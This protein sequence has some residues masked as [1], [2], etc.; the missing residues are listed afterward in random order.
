M[1]SRGSLV[2]TGTATSP[3]RMMPKYAARYSAR[4][5]DRMPMRVP[6]AKPAC[7]S[8]RATPMAIPSIAPWL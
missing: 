6:R 1:V 3:A 2:L 8:W 7:V 5:S 4:F